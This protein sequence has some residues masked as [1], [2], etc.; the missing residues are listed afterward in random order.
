MIHWLKNVGNTSKK[1]NECD[2]ICTKIFL[3]QLN[4]CKCVINVNTTAVTTVLGH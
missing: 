2:Q 3:L 1:L 4:L